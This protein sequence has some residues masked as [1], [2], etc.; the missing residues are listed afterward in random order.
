[1][2]TVSRPARTAPSAP[3]RRFGY[4]VAVAVN[5]FLLWAVHNVLGWEWTRFITDEW[6]QVLPILTTSLIAA[7]AVNT[8]Y[9]VFD[10][11]WFK[12]LTQIALSGISLAV[13]VRMLRVFPFNF[14]E[15]DF[16]WE[17]FVRVG[18]IVGIVG[19]SIAI[20][21]ETVKLIGAI[22]RG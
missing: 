14:N 12:S 1:M 22:A 11:K 17:T 4:L 10:P 15:Y 19:I 7:I 9:V 21:V 18:L 6:D 8:L 2:E 13:T 5:G 3:A 16:P 20:V